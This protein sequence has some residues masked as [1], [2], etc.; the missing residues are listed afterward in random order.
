MGARVS[1]APGFEGGLGPPGRC[2]GAAL[3]QRLARWRAIGFEFM[4][5]WRV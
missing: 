3:T 5:R 1:P 4:A 2:V